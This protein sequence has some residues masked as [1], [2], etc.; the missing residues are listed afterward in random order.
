MASLKLSG[1]AHNPS[2]KVG[3]LHRR[4]ARPDKLNERLDGLLEARAKRKKSG[5]RP[6]YETSHTTGTNTHMARR[7][8]TATTKSTDRAVTGAGDTKVPKRP[9]KGLPVVTFSAS[10]PWAVLKTTSEE[11]M[12]WKRVPGTSDRTLPPTVHVGKFND[13]TKISKS[14]YNGAV[15]M[16]MEGMRILYGP[17]DEHTT[18]AFE[19]AWVPLFDHPSQEVL[20][21]LDRLI[22]LLAKFL[23]LRETWMQAGTGFMAAMLD[24]SLSVAAEQ[25][26]AWLDAMERADQQVLV[27]RSLENEMEALARAIEALGNPPNPLADKCASARRYRRSLPRPESA[28][29]GEW[30][31]SDGSSRIYYKTVRRYADGTALVYHYSYAFA[32]QL[33][34]AGLDASRPGW[35]TAQRGKNFI[36]PGLEEVLILFSPGKDGV[37]WTQ[38][39]FF[40]S[41]LSAYYIQGDRLRVITYGLPHLGANYSVFSGTTFVRV[42]PLADKPP[43]LPGHSWEKIVAYAEKYEMERL[44]RRD[45]VRRELADRIRTLLS[46]DPDN[47]PL[48]PIRRQPWEEGPHRADEAPPNCTCHVCMKGDGSRCPCPLCRRDRERLGLKEEP[49]VSTQTHG[50]AST[51]GAA[52]NL[53]AR[54]ETIAF[55]ESMIRLL[56]RNLER[57]RAELAREPD[58]KRRRELALRIIGIQSDI[59]AEEDLVAS[60]RTGNLVHTRSAFDEFASQQFLAKVR[61]EARRVDQVRRIAGGVERQIE[62]LPEDQKKTARDQARRIL[63]A[64][65]IADGD[66]ERAKRLASA[67]N[68]QI[69]GYWSGVSAR[70]EEKAIASEESEF[71]SQMAIMASSACVVGLGQQAVAAT[72]GENAAITLWSPTLLGGIYGGTTALVSS[73]LDPVEAVKGAVSSCHTVGGLAVNFLEGYRKAREA[74]GST[75]QDAAWEGAKEAGW[76]LLLKKGM[77]IGANDVAK[78]AVHVFGKDSGIFKPLK[79]ASGHQRDLGRSVRL[80]KDLV[81]AQDLIDAF[82]SAQLG[83]ARARVNSPTSSEVAKLEKELRSLAAAINSSYHAKWLLKYKGH[84]SLQRAFSRN[85][86]AIYKDMLPEM[87]KVLK[88]QGYDTSNL[89]FKPVRNASSA[90]SVGMDLDLALVESPN[91][92]IL[93]NGKPVG[94]PEFQAD[95][96][97]A[98]NRAYHQVTGYNAARSELNLTTSVHSESYRNLD[99]LKDK[100]DFT[101]IPSEDLAQIGDVLKVKLGKIEGDPMLSPLAKVQ[102]SCRESAKE[103]KNMLLPMLRQKAA[104]A[105]SSSSEAAQ[106]RADIA[107]WERMLQHFDEIGTQATDPGR[108]LELNRAIR[109][110][111]GGRDVMEVVHGVTKAFRNR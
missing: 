53:K 4:S 28:L 21:Y 3:S 14:T 16:A 7:T 22:P 38:S 74:P 51:P 96:Q 108:I 94:I 93:K 103:I 68:D 72:F 15:A 29:D 44:K 56:Q 12:P 64:K 52:E 105:G 8:D 43:V 78:G 106:L 37:L 30:V 46:A 73:G 11:G 31:S 26:T 99:L 67:L 71:W 40:N 69:V 17:L 33:K 98:L 79:I 63:D 18:R 89:H 86:E 65:V 111:T 110:D 36:I 49:S 2:Q 27:M 20:E 50:V 23:A 32:D 58:P 25:K 82:K 34:E 10:D 102:A 60:Y 109:R 57:E 75:W 80:T 83:L 91:F 42:P 1:P 90:Q 77:E 9:P 19:A 76:D 92:I 13:L 45:Q 55:H 70:E 41:S 48:P 104:K 66:V 24:V 87:L 95:A 39:G 35:E 88:N 61:E 5:T 100:V 84:P 47:L 59:Q 62:L 107:Y 81:D 6:T 85:V 97:R 101:S 54:E